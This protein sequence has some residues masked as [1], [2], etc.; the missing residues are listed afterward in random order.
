MLEFAPKRP[1]YMS[2]Y[3]FECLSKIIK[4]NRIIYLSLCDNYTDNLLAFNAINAPNG[5]N[6]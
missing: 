4:I 5:V 1:R 6:L 2:S 3:Y